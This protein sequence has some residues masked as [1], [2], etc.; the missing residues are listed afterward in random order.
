MK[1]LRSVLHPGADAQWS[2][3]RAGLPPAPGLSAPVLLASFTLNLMSL[4]LPIVILQVYD[5]ILPNS[6]LET[7]VVL[8]AGLAVVLLLD[9]LV[10]LTRA[11]VSGWTAARFEHIAA[12]RAVDRLLASDIHELEQEAPGVHLDRLLAIDLLRDHYGGQ[13]RLLLIDLPFAA[14]FLCLIWFIAPPLVLVLLGALC[15]LSTAA[16]LVGGRSKRA[17]AERSKLDERRYSFI[18][19]VLSGMMTVKSLAMEELMQRRYELLQRAGA[20]STYQTTLYS[21]L[22]QAI[23]SLFSNLTMVAVA[24]VGALLVMAGE[25]TIGGLA[26][27]VLLAGRTVQPMLG[28]LGLWTQIQ[29]IAV[30][31]RRVEQLFARAPETGRDRGMVREISGGIELHD[32][33]FSYHPDEPPLFDGLELTITPGE[34][35]GIRGG[36]GSGKS[37]L[38]ALMMGVI[39]P[40]RG[41]VVVDGID[42]QDYDQQSL[43][44]QIAYLPQSAVLFQGT[45]LDNLTL[46]RGAAAVDDGLAAAK[47]TGLHETIN[48][49]AGGYQTIVGDGAPQ[50][51][52]SGAMQ[53]LA[54]ARALAGE[55]RLIL[56]DEANGGFDT[57]ADGRLRRVLGEIKGGPAMVLVSH[58]PSLLSLADRVYDLRDGK[59]VERADATAGRD[60][61]PDP[62]PGPQD[63]TADLQRAAL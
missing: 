37:T 25:L 11:Y 5:R 2:C 14:L 45:I 41:R 55:P 30:A 54:V 16:L 6:A 43:R 46:F 48:R 35:I 32:V 40:N 34:V 31:K 13:A 22:A 15:V 23:A 61:Q 53:G 49:L 60:Q 24:S 27:C 21:S 59:L 58:R 19:E 20:A 3:G 44:R 8:I 12:C 4:G 29:S 7:F 33:G 26:A 9:A 42:L 17:L 63:A 1:S 36:S 52:S 10:R 39:K 18:I 50:R 38:L 56:F 57:E 51:L 62:Q 47:L 28:G